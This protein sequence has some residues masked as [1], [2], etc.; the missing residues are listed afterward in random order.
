MEGREDMNPFGLDDSSIQ[1]I[2]REF[3]AKRNIAVRR[4]RRLFDVFAE[5]RSD[6]EE[7]GLKFLYAYMPLRDLADYDGTLFLQHV[8][9]SLE[10]RQKV[11]WGTK[12][13]GDLFVSFVLPYRMSNEAIEDYRGLFFEELIGRVKDKSMYDAILEINHWCHEKAT[14]TSTDPRTASPLTVVRTALGRCGEE[15]A[16]LV[17]A[18]R[19]LCIPA[20]QCYT[21]RWAHTDDNHAWVEAWADGSWYFLGVCE[22][23][24]RLNMGWFAGPSRRAMLVSAKIPGC[25]KG[26]EERVMSYDGYLSINL[27]SNYAPTRKLTV[28]VKDRQGN[29]VDSANV[30]FNVFNYG[31]FAPITRLMTD[32]NGEAT[33]TTGLGDLLIYAANS[34]GYGYAKS[35]PG[36]GDRVEIVLTSELP[37]DLDLELELTPPPDDYCASDEI[38]EEERNLHNQRLK[39]EDRIRAEYEQTFVSEQE[40][41]EL[42]T[43]LGLPSEDVCSV[44]K[45]ARGNSHTI[46]AFLRE[47]TAQYGEYALKLLQVI[48]AKDLT[49]TTPEVLLDHLEAATAF[50][51]DFDPEVFA[52]YVLN[53]RVSY[54]VLARYRRFFQ[55]EFSSEQQQ[56]FRED[57]KSLADWVMVNI[58]S[59]PAGIVAGCATPR[60]TYELGL[61]DL[62]SKK[63]LFVALAR[64]FGIPARLNR[65]DRR[66]QFMT[67][68]GWVDAFRR[69]ADK[70]ECE[71]AAASTGTLRIRLTGGYPEKPEYFRNF[72]ISRFEG[73]APRVLNLHGLSGDAVG[74]PL[75]L[76]TGYYWL[77]TGYRLAD[78]TV[79]AKIVSF[80]VSSGDQTEVD[81]KIRKDE[82]QPEQFGSV[83]AGLAIAGMDGTREEL[84]DLL[85][86]GEV[87][88]A[89]IEQGREPSKHLLRE[90]SELKDEFDEA[91][92]QIRL[93]V[94]AERLTQPLNESDYRQLPLAARFCLDEKEVLLS[95]VKEC[96]VDRVQDSLP[97][98]LLISKDRAIRY[99]SVGY[100]I[101]TGMDI[102][103][104][105]GSSRAA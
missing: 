80:R 9:R 53:P 49:D 29:L 94:E 4:K 81:L 57:P 72:T 2:E 64:S 47:H 93:L 102:L 41:R 101:G 11:P 68:Q 56:R 87:L 92:I 104:L 96:L 7:L 63:V 44:I 30:S 6:E 73:Y 32:E 98:V 12:V 54:E 100:R 1:E 59:A 88:L 40:A 90:L 103:R 52:R 8:R 71:G 60:G 19:S 61:G 5:V 55:T 35:S 70:H 14:Y 16:L 85:S 3:A 39:E 51:D 10:A 24:P 66:A 28:T 62:E 33:L 67:D 95:R 76:P 97:L 58:G 89:F 13:P 27:L 17:A 46:A 25:Y 37:E 79:L 18:L 43:E 83:P 38:S 105:I 21:P 74:E 31:S 36:T 99:V 15:S 69:A 23:E 22:P 77:T 48:S 84:D 42:A 65:A 82:K 78:G 75:T 26:P 50:R 45:N 20:R 91:G 34:R 86:R